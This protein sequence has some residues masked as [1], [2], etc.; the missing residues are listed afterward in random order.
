MDLDGRTHTTRCREDVTQRAKDLAF[1]FRMVDNE[2][3]T[4]LMGADFLLQPNEYYM[5]I[6]KQA[7][8]RASGREPAFESCGLADHIRNLRFADSPN[9]LKSP[10]T[11]SIFDGLKDSIALHR[12]V[13]YC[14]ILCHTISY[15]I[16]WHHTASCC[17]GRTS[18]ERLQLVRTVR[19]S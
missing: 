10:V 5:M 9:K 8:T 13:S 14:I 12:T 4:Y 18:N 7:K 6:V 3:W 11:G 2:R 16:V 15:R 1:G 17:I 19:E